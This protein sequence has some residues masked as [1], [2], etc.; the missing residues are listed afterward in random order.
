MGPAC[1]SKIL[2]QV[3]DSVGAFWITL[4]PIEIKLYLPADLSHMLFSHIDPVAEP[5]DG[6]LIVSKIDLVQAHSTLGCK[7]EVFLFVGSV[8]YRCSISTL[9]APHFFCSSMIR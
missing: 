8:Y 4:H 2:V 1:I 9:A 3:Q 5:L 7:A 6:R